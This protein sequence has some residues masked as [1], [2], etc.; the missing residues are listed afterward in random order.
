MEPFKYQWVVR[1]YVI[2]NPETVYTFSRYKPDGSPS[3][4]EQVNKIKTFR[5][6]RDAFDVAKE[7]I[8]TEKYIA[9]VYK[10]CAGRNDHY[11]F[12]KG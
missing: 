7:L 2:G 3:H 1:Y 8:E 5:L 12:I 4:T 6:Y 11:Y 10:I 9:S